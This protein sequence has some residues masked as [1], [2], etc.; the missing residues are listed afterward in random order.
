MS[1]KIPTIGWKAGT[2]TI[3]IGPGTEKP[4]PGEQAREWWDKPGAAE[5]TEGAFHEMARKVLGAS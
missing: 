1:A 5:W 2:F 3:S 4:L